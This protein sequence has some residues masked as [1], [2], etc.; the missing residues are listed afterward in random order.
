[1]IQLEVPTT[2][3]LDDGSHISELP[4]D[5]FGGARGTNL[6]SEHLIVDRKLLV[7]RNRLMNGLIG[8]NERYEA[9]LV[10]AIASINSATKFFLNDEIATAL[11]ANLS[12]A[13]RMK[14]AMKMYSDSTS[15]AL[16]SDHFRKV[17]SFTAIS[18]EVLETVEKNLVVNADFL[19]LPYPKM[20]IENGRFGVLIEAD[21]LDPYMWK[22]RNFAPFYV[23]GGY[24]RVDVRKSLRVERGSVYL[25]NADYYNVQERRP[26]AS[27][28]N[29]EHTEVSRSTMA[30]KKMTEKA[31]N[32]FLGDEVTGL[33]VGMFVVFFTNMSNV[34]IHTYRMRKGEI[35][36]AIPNSLLPK[37]EYRVLDLFRERESLESFDDVKAFASGSSRAVRDRRAH[38]VRG[39]FKRKGG[40][41]FWWNAHVRNRHNAD[42]VGVVE[43]DYRVNSEDRVAA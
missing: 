39:H 18:K 7:E 32:E 17:R 25:E 24:F 34:R 30:A 40:K 38:L 41:L 3:L 8:K 14:I 28:R 19:A 27:V 12:A 9:T 36:K 15:N 5:K 6:I 42:T 1:M 43:K 10:E 2:A 4:M 31:M 37:Y 21:P 16:L 20:F 26:M 33:L 29:G 22:V 23:S 35:S 13:E 11:T